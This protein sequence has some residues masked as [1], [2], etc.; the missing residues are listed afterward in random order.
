MLAQLIRENIEIIQK[1]IHQGYINIESVIEKI[2]NA[3]E[4]NFSEFYD[5]QGWS[6]IIASLYALSG[7]EGVNLFCKNLTDD[8]SFKS[9]KIWF[10]VLPDSPRKNEGKTHLDFALGSVQLRPGT[11]SGIQPSNIKFYDDINKFAFC[12]CK[13][14]SDL[15]TSVSCDKHRNQ[16]IRVIENAFCFAENAGSRAQ[17]YV[18]LITPCVFISRK[19]FSRLFQYKFNEYF[20]D[21]SSILDEFCQ[22]DKIRYS[23]FL[24]C[25]DLKWT[26]YEHLIETAPQNVL[27]NQVKAFAK[28]FNKTV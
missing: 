5:E 24:D 7:Q 21:K 25:V 8:D 17:I 27:L 9:E 4:Q 26:S 3:E 11:L 23:K 20:C 6:F 22:P 2:E 16:L 15:S 12:E 1:Y 28:K 19:P 10:E 13:W 14:Y 18:V